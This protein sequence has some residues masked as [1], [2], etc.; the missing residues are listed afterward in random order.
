MIS[1]AEDNQA[2]MEIVKRLKNENKLLS[3]S[4][5]IF[6]PSFTILLIQRNIKGIAMSIDFSNSGYTLLL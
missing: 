1:Y 3:A 5:I 6:N 4:K 2:N